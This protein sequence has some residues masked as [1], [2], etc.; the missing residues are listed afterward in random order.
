[1]K[2]KTEKQRDKSM[3]QGAGSEKR[4]IKNEQRLP[5]RLLQQNEN[6]EILETTPCI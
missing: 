3:K 5:L 2:L 4:V 1:M 6:K